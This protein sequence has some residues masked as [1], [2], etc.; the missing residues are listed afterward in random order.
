MMNLMSLSNQRIFAILDHT[1]R[2]KYEH[3]LGVLSD[4]PPSL[5]LRG[6]FPSNICVLHTYAGLLDASPD[7]VIASYLSRISDGN[8][9]VSS[10]EVE[11][12]RTHCVRSYSDHLRR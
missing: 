1:T 12:T 4:H 10:A 6:C 3:T 7:K 5:L 11:P 9:A 2:I 8:N